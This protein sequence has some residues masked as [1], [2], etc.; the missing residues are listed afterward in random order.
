MMSRYVKRLTFGTRVAKPEH[1]SVTPEFSLRSPRLVADKF[2][3]KLVKKG[4]DDVDW[5]VGT[6]NRLEWPVLGNTV[7]KHVS[8][9]A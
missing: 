4:A 5:I 7:P 3:G 9:P 6:Q 8:E 2:V 1:G